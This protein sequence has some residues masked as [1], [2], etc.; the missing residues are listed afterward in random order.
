MS[1]NVTTMSFFAEF[2]MSQQPV[3]M[4]KALLKFTEALASYAHATRGLR[5]AA[6]R[7]QHHAGVVAAAAESTGQ[8]FRLQP[9]KLQHSMS[10]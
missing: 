5:H 4:Q 2:E 6:L 7:T 8:H 9:A 1:R 10:A 3:N